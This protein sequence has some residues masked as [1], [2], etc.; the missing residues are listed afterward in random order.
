MCASVSTKVRGKK[1]HIFVF[2]KKMLFPAV[3]RLKFSKT[4]L[5][6]ILSHIFFTV[7]TLKLRGT[8]FGTSVRNAP[9]KDHLKTESVSGTL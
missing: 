8:K 4:I 5:F 3:G 7:R 2:F 6:G 9:I 1:M